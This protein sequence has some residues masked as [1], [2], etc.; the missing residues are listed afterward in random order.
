[1][2]LFNKNGKSSGQA[3]AEAALIAPLIVFFLFTVIWFARIMLTWQQLTSAARYGMD[4]ISYT[5]FSKNVI[6]QEITNYLCNDKTIG[7]I[8][9]PQNLDIDVK[10]HDAKKIN[11][12]FEFE[13]ISSFNPL[14]IVDEVKDLFALTAEKSYVEVSYKYRA[15]AALRAAGR[16]EFKIKARCEVLSGTGS[17]GAQEREK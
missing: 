3:L 5:P 15:P 13:N 12:T 9:D 8:L 2:F 10:I 16:E 6:K 7:R 17:Y 4:L 11:T 14:K 1:M